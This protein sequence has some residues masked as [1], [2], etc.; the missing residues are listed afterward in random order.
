MILALSMLGE[1]DQLFCRQLFLSL[2]L[3]ALPGWLSC[4]QK[5]QGVQFLKWIQ[6]SLAHA[7]FHVSFIFDRDDIGQK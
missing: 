3:Q 4:E 7:V 1:Y 2:C 6:S 5:P